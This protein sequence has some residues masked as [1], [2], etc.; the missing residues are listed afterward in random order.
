MAKKLEAIGDEDV[1]TV[2]SFRECAKIRIDDEADV[3]ISGEENRELYDRYIKAYG[4]MQLSHG[5]CPG[6]IDKLMKEID[7]L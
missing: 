6:H 5:Y 3:W 4:D 1:L 7:K 2:C